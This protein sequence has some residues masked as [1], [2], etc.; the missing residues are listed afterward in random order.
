M[1]IAVSG[2]GPAKS[3]SERAFTQLGD[4]FLKSKGYVIDPSASDALNPRS[5]YPQ[6]IYLKQGHML[7][8]EYLETGARLNRKQEEWARIMRSIADKSNRAVT[9]VAIQPK[10][11]NELRKAAV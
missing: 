6:R 2:V 9:Y 1:A 8:V 5:G 4:K 11:W 10:D 3:I 7:I